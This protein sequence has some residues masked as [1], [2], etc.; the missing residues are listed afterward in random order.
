MQLSD[1]SNSE[2]SLDAQNVYLVSKESLKKIK[3]LFCDKCHKPGEGG[4]ETQLS[5]KNNHVSKSQARPSDPLGNPQK[6]FFRCKKV[7]GFLSHEGGGGQRRF[8]ICHKK[9]VFII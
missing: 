8:D 4:L 7:G 1:S 2:V 3:P 5:K 9:V 6:V